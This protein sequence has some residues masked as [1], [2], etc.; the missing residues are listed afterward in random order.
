VQRNPPVS[1]P[2]YVGPPPVIEPPFKR[3]D[4]VWSLRRAAWLPKKTG[5]GIP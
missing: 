3:Q 1:P 5:A 2:Y 4:F